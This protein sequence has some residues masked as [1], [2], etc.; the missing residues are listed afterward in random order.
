MRPDLQACLVSLENKAL[1][2]PQVIPVLMA[3][4]VRMVKKVLKG[5]L[6]SKVQWVLVVPTEN[7]ALWALLVNPVNPVLPVQSDL[8]A[9]L[10]NPVNAV[11]QAL[12]VH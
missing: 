3:N 5:L 4:R 1:L 12:Q 9:W 7:P 8:L 6:V 11:P 2:D 10:V